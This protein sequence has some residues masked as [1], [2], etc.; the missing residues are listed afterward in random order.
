MNA[1]PVPGG[2]RRVELIVIL[3]ALTAAAPISTDL[4]LPALPAIARDFHVAIGAVEHSLATFFLGFALGQALFGPLADRFGRKPPLLWG[5]GIFVLTCLACALAQSVE[6]LV[7]LRFVQAVSAC[8]GAVIARACVRDLFGPDESPR[9][10]ATMM[11]VMGLA[12]LLAP[13]AGGYL[14]LWFGWRA[15]FLAQGALG[16]AAFLA[17]A[18]RLRESH[19]GAR[20]VLHL[21]SILI[22]YGRLARDRRF[23]G[24]VLALATSYAGLFAYIT[25]SPHVLIDLFHV[26]SQHFGW[27]FGANGL[28]LIA[29]S[30][31]AARLLR[32]RSAAPVLVAM[33]IG[34]SVAGALLLAAALS[35]FGGLWSI[36]GLLVFTVGPTGAINPLATGLAM[37]P[38]ALSAGMASS[39]LGTIQFGGGAIASLIVGALPADSAVPMAAAIAACSLGGLVLNLWLSPKT[40]ES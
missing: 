1:T 32:T 37:R 35:G 36:A 28:A 34:Q 30:Q 3:G 13:L 25:A 14:L 18:L 17:A 2:A 7:A 6:V 8:A 22:D 27:F 5:L 40:A 12:P 15:I 26:P 4:Y 23:I 29:A 19:G 31:V 39:L 11:L 10:F 21:G 20:R 9:V 33:Q 24:Y 38:F 16:I